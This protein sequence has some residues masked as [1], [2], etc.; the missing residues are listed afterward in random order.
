MIKVLLI[1]DNEDNRLSMTILL[2]S[3][4]FKVIEAE[5]GRLG[6]EAAITEQ[7]DVILLDIQL[8]DMEGTEVL[9]RLL[10]SESTRD[11][12]VIA[13]TSYAMS[14]DRQRLLAA[15]CKEYIEKPFDP[16]RVVD[17]VRTIIGSS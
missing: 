1:E 5:T 11:I 10:E 3:G 13:V 14:G 6:L 7:P 8:P 9:K 4:G 15:G 17:Q 2:E 12:P 16:M